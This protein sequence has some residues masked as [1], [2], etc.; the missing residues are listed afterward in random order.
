LRHVRNSMG[1][2]QTFWLQD[3]SNAYPQDA[4]FGVQHHTGTFTHT[5][6][7][8]EFSHGHLG[9]A[10]QN[11]YDAVNRQKIHES[12]PIWT[13]SSRT[14]IPSV[15]QSFENG[16]LSMPILST[17]P[18][19]QTPFYVNPTDHI[20][21]NTMEQHWRTGEPINRSSFPP[22]P[23]DPWNIPYDIGSFDYKSEPFNTLVVPEP[24]AKNAEPVSEL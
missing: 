3:L 23:A 8:S 4:I 17:L 14:E 20:T 6:R 5:L 24:Q 22:L 18:W 9:P 11:N 12:S 13:A 2:S 19:A 1:R 7:E 10:V 15:S 16:S 21:R